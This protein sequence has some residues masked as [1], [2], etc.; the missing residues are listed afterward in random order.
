MGGH[1]PNQENPMPK[2]RIFDHLARVSL[3][4]YLFVT[5]QPA[6]AAWNDENRSYDKAH[7]AVAEG[8]ALPLPKIIEHLRRHVSDDIVALEYE[9][10]FDRW[11]YEFK[12]VDSE[13]R[14]QR[15]HLDAATGEQVNERN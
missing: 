3:L 11:V 6:A 2:N 13:G 14:L 4:I 9:Y 5:A 1:R 8:A 7:R 10:E 12:I 15:I